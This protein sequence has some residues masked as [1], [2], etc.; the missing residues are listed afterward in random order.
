MFFE[1]DLRRISHEDFLERFRPGRSSHIQRNI[2]IWKMEF[3]NRK[4]V[5][6]ET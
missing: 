1:K 5:L 6:D 2:F 3:N 4:G